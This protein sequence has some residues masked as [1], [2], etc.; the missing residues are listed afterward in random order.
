MGKVFYSLKGV[1]GWVRRVNGID[2]AAVDA[3]RTNRFRGSRTGTGQNLMCQTNPVFPQ[4][5]INVQNNTTVEF[6]TKQLTPRSTI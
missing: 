1:L 4:S 5:K 2:P 6:Y 3:V